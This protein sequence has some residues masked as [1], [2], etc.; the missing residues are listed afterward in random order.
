MEDVAVSKPAPDLYLEACERLGVDPA[1][2]AAFEDSPRAP[3]RPQQPDS[4]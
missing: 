2:T 3:R 1:A 4:S